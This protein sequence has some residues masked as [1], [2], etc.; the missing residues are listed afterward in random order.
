MTAKNTSYFLVKFKTE[1]Y[2]FWDRVCLNVN[3][4]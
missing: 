4:F 1:H 2:K 3:I